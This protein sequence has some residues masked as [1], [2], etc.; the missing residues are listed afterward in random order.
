[1]F[2]INLNDFKCCDNCFH[3][4]RSSNFSEITDRLLHPL[5][6]TTVAECV[7]IVP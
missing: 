7:A 6:A 4:E 2:L 3:P 5:P 1:M